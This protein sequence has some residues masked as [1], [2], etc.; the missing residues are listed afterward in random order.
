[1]ASIENLSMFF[2]LALFDN[3]GIDGNLEAT[4]LDKV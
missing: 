3:P 1:M 2:A 4:I